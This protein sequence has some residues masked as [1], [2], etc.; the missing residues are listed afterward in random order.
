MS[1]VRRQL[2]I[3]LYHTSP[4]T[5]CG[6]MLVDGLHKWP[7]HR[8]S[9][10]TE[11]DLHYFVLPRANGRA[12]LCLLHD[13]AQKG[14]FTGPGQHEKFLG[15]FGFRV[16]SRQ[17]DVR[18]RP[19]GSAMRVLPDERQ[20]GRSTLCARLV[21]I[22]DAAGWKDPIIG[23]GLSIALRDVRIVTDILRS[24]R[25]GRRQ[26]L[27]PTVKNAGNGCAGCE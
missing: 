11:G 27:L 6:G 15:A 2:G 22:G 13:I 5:M 4:R 20:L 12:R 25:I 17:R 7:A 8:F 23:Q 21:L 14:R 1:T 19:S 24:G 10:G 9:L 26:P 3:E 18:C 16:H